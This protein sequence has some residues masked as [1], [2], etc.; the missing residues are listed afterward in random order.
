M[1]K[2]KDKTMYGFKNTAFLTTQVHTLLN[3]QWQTSCHYNQHLA[4][5]GKVECCDN[6]EYSQE[7][8]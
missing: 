2:V 1:K 8:S 5:N 7:N 6:P 3:L 4:N